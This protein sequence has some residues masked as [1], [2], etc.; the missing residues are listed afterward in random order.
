VIIVHELV[1]KL[2]IFTCSK[3]S[4]PADLTSNLFFVSFHASALILLIR[5]LDFVM[6]TIP[7]LQAKKKKPL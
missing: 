1:L 2:C 6:L 5:R 4:V 7:S 3:K